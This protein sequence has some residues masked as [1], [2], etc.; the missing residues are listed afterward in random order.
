MFVT[1]KSLLHTLLLPPGGPLLLAGAGLWLLLR[2]RASDAARKAGV[3]L[4][5]AGLATLWLLSTLVVA[6]ALARLAEHYPPLDLSR[7][8]RG[9]AIVILGGGTARMAPE[10]GGPA[11]GFEL[12]E[13]VSYGAYVA[14]H[15]G[16]PVLVSGS[17]NEALAMSAVLA[18]DF[19]IRTR[20][21][22]GQSGDT[23]ENARFSARL[24]K[25]DGITR[26]VLVTSSTHEWRA[27]QEF[28]SAGLSVEPAPAHVLAP[29]PVHPLID[30]LPTP[31]GL[32][33]STEG[34]YEILG[35][36]VRQLL[37]ATHL[38]RHDAEEPPPS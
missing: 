31:R 13:R 33:R 5:V 11:A 15:T 17:A 37:A 20:W 22:D 6:D 7:P 26:I 30:Y 34:M 25:A 29:P 2:R 3:A 4:A 24:L 21:V 38:R 19:G 14:R 10:Y 32:A 12:L 16:L 23:F 1:L 27:A 28:M 18:R 9:Q 35:N 36:V 8:V